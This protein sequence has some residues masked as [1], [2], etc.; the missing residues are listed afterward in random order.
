MKNKKNWPNKEFWILYLC[1]EIVYFAYW[2][3]S[4]L[5]IW[6]LIISPILCFIA[7][8]I[9]VIIHTFLTETIFKK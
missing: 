4:K 6:R 2:C 7:T 9:V 8:F 1:I 5:D 3:Y